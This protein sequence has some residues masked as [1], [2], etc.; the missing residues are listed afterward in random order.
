M[1][2]VRA[3]SCSSWATLS[4]HT[5]FF[6]NWFC[7]QRLGLCRAASAGLGDVL[8]QDLHV[9][10]KDPKVI[11]K[12]FM[13]DLQAHCAT[14]EWAPLLTHLQAKKSFTRFQ[15][16]QKGSYLGALKISLNENSQ[17]SRPC[18]PH[19]NIIPYGCKLSELVQ[20]PPW[21]PWRGSISTYITTQQCE[22]GSL[23]TAWM[24]KTCV[25]QT[26]WA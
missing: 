2:K 5:C 15:L 22:K 23:V 16:H 20:L 13:R 24:L 12:Q 25:D 9:S 6:G 19:R 17:P 8:I 3:Y 7:S 18:K 14:S 4:W 10:Q 1:G 21:P 26:S 11:Y